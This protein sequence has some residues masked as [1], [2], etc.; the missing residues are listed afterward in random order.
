VH[1]QVQ[2]LLSATNLHAIAVPATE[3]G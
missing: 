1:V 3:V 2:G